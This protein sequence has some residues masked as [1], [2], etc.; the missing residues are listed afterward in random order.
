MNW[1]KE[2]TTLRG[3]IVDLLP[4]SEQHF[5]ELESLARDHRI[6]EFISVDMSSPEKCRVTFIQA[7]KEREKGT[8]FPF[9]IYHKNEK[10]IIG[11]TRLMEMVPEH[12]KLEIGWTWLHPDHWAT[13]VNPECKLLL[14]TFCFEELKTNRV[15]LKTDENNIRS[16][17]AIQKIGGRYE[18]FFRQ[19]HIR[20]NGTIRNT[21]YFSI[22]KNEWENVKVNL[23]A[24]FQKSK[25]KN[26][27]H[28]LS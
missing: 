28:H 26:E 12:K 14:L 10:R 24:L 17:T 22:I 9:V 21:V 15:Q 1:I 23:S 4:L 5:D 16:R 13:S 18:G 27:R 7:L 19:D 11:C 8:Q 25:I 20:D 2:G 6:W 3:E